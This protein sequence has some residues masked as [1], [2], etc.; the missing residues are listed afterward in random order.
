MRRNNQD[1]VRW[2]L[3]P[4]SKCWWRRSTGGPFHYETLVRCST[5]PRLNSHKTLFGC[6]RL[7]REWL[8]DVL[9]DSD[10]RLREAQRLGQF[11]T[12][13][14]SPLLR[15]S[16]PIGVLLISRVAVR[17]FDGKHIELL[18]TFADQTVIAIDN[19]RL[20]NELR[21]RTDDLSEFIGSASDHLPWRLR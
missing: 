14:G 1:A 21:Q 19:T 20:L 18:T 16:N 10:Y 2:R 17:P 15:E 4:A 12:H 5:R 8:A 13:L 7:S 11:P 6:A 9:A 3:L